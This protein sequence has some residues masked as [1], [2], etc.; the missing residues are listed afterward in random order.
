[1]SHEENMVFSPLDTNDPIQ[2]G[3]KEALHRLHSTVDQDQCVVFLGH[4]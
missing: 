2:G 1:M 3:V 4:L